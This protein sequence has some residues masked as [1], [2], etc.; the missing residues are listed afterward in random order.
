MRRF[1]QTLCYV[2]PLSPLQVPQTFVT[3]PARK[4][5]SPK[6]SERRS[7]TK[8]D[9]GESSIDLLFIFYVLSY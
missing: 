7:G 6:S 8:A 4:N 2:D 1:L 3:R 9:T 5:C